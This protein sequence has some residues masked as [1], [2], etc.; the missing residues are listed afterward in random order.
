MPTPLVPT[1]AVVVRHLL[2]KGQ[3]LVLSVH[4]DVDV[5]RRAARNSIRKGTHA[6]VER[7]LRPMTA[8]EVFLADPRAFDC[9]CCAD[10]GDAI[11]KTHA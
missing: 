3:P 9:D 7:R 6:H 2:R 11:A 4:D 1:Y 5:A 10:A 8:D